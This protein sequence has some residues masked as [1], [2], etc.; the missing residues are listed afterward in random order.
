MTGSPPVVMSQKSK[1]SGVSTPI[2]V[3]ASTPVQQGRP[4]SPLSPTRLSRLQEKTD[5]QGLNDRLACYIDRVRFLEQE[6]S[7]LT[8]EVRTSQETVTREV[9]NIKQMYEHELTDARKLLD[10]T[11]RE[12]AKLEIDAKRIWEENDDLKKRYVNPFYS[13]CFCTDSLGG[14]RHPDCVT[15]RTPSRKAEASTSDGAAG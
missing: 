9:S 1:R 10:E 12:K 14:L 6:N 13:G 7:R 5:L 15:F 3:S 2:P 4:Q 11:A 8:L